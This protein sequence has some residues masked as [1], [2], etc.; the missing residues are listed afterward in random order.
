MHGSLTSGHIRLGSTDVAALPLPYHCTRYRGYSSPLRSP[1]SSSSSSPVANLSLSLYMEGHSTPLSSPAAASFAHTPA[2]AKYSE[3]VVGGEPSPPFPPPEKVPIEPPS[4]A[5]S[6]SCS[7]RR[8]PVGDLDAAPSSSF[9][10]RRAGRSVR[11]R[12]RRCS[13]SA[14]MSSATSRPKGGH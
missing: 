10:D 5:I 3:D 8:P 9:A 12:H 1:A 11:R 13:L 7:G 6:F 4:P 14:G 2:G